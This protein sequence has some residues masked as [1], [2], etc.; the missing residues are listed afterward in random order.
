M[1]TN[2]SSPRP[3]GANR[4]RPSG[5]NRLL[6][7]AT[8]GLGLA[9]SCVPAVAQAAPPAR[10][11]APVRSNAPVSLAAPPVGKLTPSGCVRSGQDVSCQLWAKPGTAQVLGRPL[12][13]WGYS[14]GETDPATAPGPQLVLQ[15]GD[16]VTVTLHNGLAQPTALAFP[17]QPSSAFTGGLSAVGEDPGV[18]PGGTAS[19][20]FTADR[21][22]T[23]VYEAGHTA[24]GTRQVA[25]GLAGALVVLPTDPSGAYGTAA[26]AYDDEA[27]LVLSEIDPRL[28]A[29]PATFDMRGFR[30]RY[31]LVNGKAFPSTDPVSTDQGHTVL[32]RYVNVGALPHEMELLGTDQRQVAVDGHAATYATGELVADVQ[33]GTTVD[34]LATMPSGPE[35]KVTLFE[36]GGHLDNNG[37]A[38][39]DPT[40]LAF[41]GMMTVLDTNAP[42]DP[43]DSIGPV[44]AHV[45]ASPNPSDGK[46]DVTVTAD[47]SDA[48]T[49]G[50][51]VDAAEFVVDDAT[52]TGAGFGTPM[53][54]STTATGATATGTLP[55]V[56]DCTAVPQPVALSCLSSGTHRIFVRGR[57]AAGNWGVIGD[58]VLR[59]P[60]AGPQTRDG[61]LDPMPANGDEPVTVSATGDDSGAKG[62]IDGAEMFLDT[63]GDPGTGTPLTV[64]RPGGIASVDG[65]IG[66]DVL[67]TLPEGL[68]HV[69]VRTHDALGLWGPELDLPLVIDRTGPAVN[70]AAVMPNP[71]NGVVDDPGNPGNVVVSAQIQDAATLAANGGVVEAEGFL[72]PGPDPQ[73]G[74][75]F[76]MLAVDG[77][78]DSLTEAVY[79]LIPVSDIRAL[80]NGMHE[81]RV[82]GRDAAGN[83]G[84]LFSAPLAVDKTAPV[85]GDLTAAPNPTNGAATFTVSGAVDETSFGGAE[86]FLGAVDPGPGNAT[87]IQLNVANG[88][89]SVTV[90]VPPFTVGN[91]DVSLR[92]QDLAGNWS[93]L[94]TVTVRI[95]PGNGTGA[96]GLLGFG[97]TV[98]AMTVSPLAGLPRTAQNT[99]ALV[100]LPGGA[101]N[102]PAYVTAKSRAGVRTYR[103]AFSFSPHDL[104]L[105][106]APV[107][108]FDGRTWAGK[109]VFSV[110]LRGSG[111]H[112]QVRG[113]MA[114]SGR[115]ALTGEWKPLARGA[116]KV[117]LQWLAG[118][119]SGAAAHGTLRVLVD[120]R[121]VFEQQADTATLR[122]GRLRLGAADGITGT[123]RGTAYVDGFSSV[124]GLVP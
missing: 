52:T 93:N 32:L 25:M 49:G 19:Y 119:A 13:I 109:G 72:D 94:Q 45:T 4:L 40:Q 5:A 74:T 103:A 124:A 62:T 82:R 110:Q 58:V 69:L 50:S 96:A 79:G 120:G 87:P 36:A 7:A 77:S 22:G 81:I 8:L 12:P 85:L 31:R 70:A 84:P 54:L 18:A 41:G 2:L 24:N 90:P 89:A 101:R 14:T 121:R 60:K 23:F 76:D 33:P 71:S 3:S 99:G 114:R 26:T 28:N 80:D 86:V 51:G 34:T 37:E 92:V 100:S 64:N 95:R 78:F 83:W 15:Q 39:T 105:G 57:D 112:V 91:V 30:A 68:H 98:G 55:A 122:L 11:S 115:P 117:R 1:T 10:A 113:V 66:T 111:S 63:L 73:P 46:A 75:G 9:V 47:L 16:H 21:P 20:S 97:R 65:T 108:L 43:V 116:H 42:P 44:P 67:A 27:V 6:V 104:R 48:T 38:Q 102:A 107:T 123:A 17:G 61:S 35:S 29:A 56:A 106:T 118:R 53:G 88:L 59:L